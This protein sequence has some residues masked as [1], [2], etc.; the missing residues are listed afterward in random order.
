MHA[1]LNEGLFDKPLFTVHM[2]SC[3]GN[4]TEGGV[5]TFGNEDNQNCEAVEGWSDVEGDSDHWKFTVDAASMDGVTY[6]KPYKA[7]TDTGTSIIV[8][9]G[10]IV[11][12][13]AAVRLN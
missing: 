10:K 9:P 12:L 4:C 2:K 8:A 1:A 6:R 11:R 7:I 3:P 13:F 5:I